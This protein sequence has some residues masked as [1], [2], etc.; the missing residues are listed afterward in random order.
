MKLQNM[1]VTYVDIAKGISMIM[2]VRIHTECAYEMNLPYPIIAVPF[3]FF[4]S[5][6]FDK[7]ERPWRMWL[8]KNAYSLLIPAFIWSLITWIFCMALSIVKSGNIDDVTISFSL[9]S[10]FIGSGVTWFF[11]ALFWAKV[12]IGIFERLFTKDVKFRKWI[13]YVCVVALCWRLAGIDMPLMIDEGFAALPFYLL[14]K[15]LY[16]QI[17]LI[18]ANNL[19]VI[20][21]VLLSFVMLLPMFPAAVISYNTECN[22]ILQYPFFCFIII[23]SFSPLLRLCMFFEK[24]IWLSEFG[25]H[26]LGVLVIHPLCLHLFAVVLNRTFVIGT[27]EWFIGFIIAFFVTII[28]SF[29]LARFIS[30]K[31]PLLLGK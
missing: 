5:G 23:C 22:S 24:C 30:I 14:G 28:M 6:F 26:T 11:V 8:R 4:L 31:C 1:R 27:V 9:Y 15:N 7:S 20:I 21:C 19:F 17:K 16:P 12:L 3:F 2:I 13:M 25:Q 10:P 29:Y 18:C